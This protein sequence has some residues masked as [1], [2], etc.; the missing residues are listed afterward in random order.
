MVLLLNVAVGWV[1][2]PLHIPEATILNLGP[3]TGY[4]DSQFSSV[5][6]SN[7]RDILN[8]ATAVFFH[9]IFN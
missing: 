3:G 7:S 5:S 6:P 9:I 1:A 4:L 2:I 8:Y